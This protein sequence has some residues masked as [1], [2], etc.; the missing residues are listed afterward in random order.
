MMNTVLYSERRFNLF[1]ANRLP[2]FTARCSGSPRSCEMF[3][4]AI[5]KKMDQYQ[6]RHE[7]QACAADRRITWAVQRVILVTAFAFAVQLVIHI[8]VPAMHPEAAPGLLALRWLEFD[9]S[10]FPMNGMLWQPFTY[11]FLH[12]GL[13]HLFTNMLWLYVFGPDVERVLGTRQFIQFYLLCGALAVLV[14]HQ[15]MILI[16]HYAGLTPNFP[17]SIP[18]TPS[19]T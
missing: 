6:Y 9:P 5:G 13:L 16:L 4:L 7:Y 10:G 8:F 19:I 2:Q 12:G 3:G 18:R 17:W 15:G 14:F 11:M 1:C